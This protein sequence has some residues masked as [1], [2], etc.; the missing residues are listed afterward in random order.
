MPL[1]TMGKHTLHIEDPTTLY[2]WEYFCG[3]ASNPNPHFPLS[4]NKHSLATSGPALLD[5]DV[6]YGEEG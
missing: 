3:M 4:Q 2:Q 1:V 5:V 6:A